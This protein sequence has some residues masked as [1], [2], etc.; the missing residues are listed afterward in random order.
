MNN[1]IVGQSSLPN[2]K[3]SKTEAAVRAVEELKKYYYTIKV[4]TNFVFKINISQF[5][6][7]RNQFFY[8]FSYLTG[9]SH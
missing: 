7:F 3:Q 4:K 6:E 5:Y 8:L 1:K 9:T 2:K